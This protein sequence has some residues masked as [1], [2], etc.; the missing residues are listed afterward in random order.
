MIENLIRP[1]L[2][3]IIR[4]TSVQNMKYRI[5]VFRSA[6][7][8]VSCTLAAGGRIVIRNTIRNKVHPGPEYRVKLNIRLFL[9]DT[10]FI[11][12]AGY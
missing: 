8:R 7:C 1:M 2:L 4:V 6:T 10:E 9:P 3:T 5:M 11:G 12:L